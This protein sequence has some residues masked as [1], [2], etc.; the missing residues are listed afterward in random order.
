MAVG[1][2]DEVFFF[3]PSKCT[4]TTV[5]LVSQLPLNNYY[6]STTVSIVTPTIPS[7]LYRQ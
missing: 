4:K 2:L 6:I 5:Y 1:K 7:L 3:C